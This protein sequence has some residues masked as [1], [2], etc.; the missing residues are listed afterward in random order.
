MACLEHECLGC[1]YLF[2]NNSTSEACPECGGH[3][4]TSHFDEPHEV[5]DIR[6][7]V[8]LVPEGGMSG[9]FPEDLR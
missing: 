6:D 5:Q 8:E 2:F 7:E 4:F 1:G 9:H 3:E